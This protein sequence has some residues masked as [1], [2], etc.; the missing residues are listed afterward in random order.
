MHLGVPWED[1]SLLTYGCTSLSQI[2]E[3]GWPFTP[4]SMCRATPSLLSIPHELHQDRN[5]T[6]QNCLAVLMR[7]AMEWNGMGLRPALMNTWE[8]AFVMYIGL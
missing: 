6:Y 8:K 2:Q 3:V 4:T 5:L 7:V 1:E